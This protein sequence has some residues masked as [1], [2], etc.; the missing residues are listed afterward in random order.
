MRLY[1][2]LNQ[3]IDLD[4]VLSVTEPGIVPYL[5]TEDL[6]FDIILSFRHSKG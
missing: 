3:Y 5:E 4:H 2:L 1:K 6:G